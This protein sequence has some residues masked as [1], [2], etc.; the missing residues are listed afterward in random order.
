MNKK[1]NSAVVA[2]EKKRADLKRRLKKYWV[3]YVLAIIPVT[4]LA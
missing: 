4:Y 2:K 3:L 1:E